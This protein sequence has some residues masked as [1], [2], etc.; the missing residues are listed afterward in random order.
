MELLKKLWPFS[1]VNKKDVAALVINVI[2]H[3]LADVIIGVLIGVL[4][5][6]PVVG[7][8]FSLLGSII[9]I[10][11]TAGIVFTFLDYFKVFEKK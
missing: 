7:I 11:I 8:I 6:I 4:V 5:G 3:V 10:Y 1:F 2:I 9:G